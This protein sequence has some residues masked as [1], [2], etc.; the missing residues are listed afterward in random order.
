M[1]ILYLK[2]FVRQ[3]KKLPEEIQNLAEKKELLFRKN[4]FDPR[5]KTHKLSGQLSGF[6]AFSIT[7]DYRIIFD[8]ATDKSVRFYEV[9]T[10]DIYR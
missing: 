4:I 5:L 6:Y 3:Y 1:K 9:G 7:N 2:K 10:H 8:I